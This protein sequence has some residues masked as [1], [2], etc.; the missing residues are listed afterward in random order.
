MERLPSAVLTVCT[1]NLQVK[2]PAA[3]EQTKARLKR[4]RGAS[5]P[6]E[7]PAIT[8]D[9]SINVDGTLTALHE[10]APDRPPMTKR[11]RLSSLPEPPDGALSSLS[12]HQSTDTTDSH[13]E[14]ERP[15]SFASLKERVS[16]YGFELFTRLSDRLMGDGHSLYDSSPP[17]WPAS[18]STSPHSLSKAPH[19]NDGSWAVS[20][21]A[22]ILCDMALSQS[23]ASERRSCSEQ[24]HSKPS[25]SDSLSQAVRTI[26]ICTTL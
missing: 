14:N 23:P 1:M 18:C 12:D 13:F 3:K 21:V 5:P 24:Q 4:E 6:C 9:H 10:H 8:M 25:L 16:S 7:L 20:A 26:S 17:T 22:R 2:E 11:T 15:S 19:S